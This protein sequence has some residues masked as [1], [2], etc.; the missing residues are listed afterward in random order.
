MLINI[1]KYI[2]LL[3]HLKED[4]ADGKTSIHLTKNDFPELYLHTAKVDNIEY[5]TIKV[6]LPY[7]TMGG[8]YIPQ[9]KKK[10][11]YYKSVYKY[12]E[13]VLNYEKGWENVML[14]LDIPIKQYNID[15]ILARVKEITKEYRAK[16]QK[17]IRNHK[18]TIRNSKE[19]IT[20]YQKN[21]ELLNQTE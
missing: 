6:E 20:K 3:K 13:Y 9:K 18:R 7:S 8:D 1:E 19:M 17:Y 2:R 14:N 16:T 11:Y 4:K 21:I 5:K 15:C 10:K 12:N